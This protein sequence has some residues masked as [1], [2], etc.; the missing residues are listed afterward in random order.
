MTLFK[1][2]ETLSTG[3]ER[4]SLSRRTIRR[5][6]N[7]MNV[8]PQTLSYRDFIPLRRRRGGMHRLL[9]KTNARNSNKVSILFRGY[10]LRSTSFP[11][12]PCQHIYCKKCLMGN[13][14][15][16]ATP[17]CPSCRETYEADLDGAERVPFTATQ[18][19]DALLEIAQDWARID[20]HGGEEEP[21]D[22]EEEETPFINDDHQDIRYTK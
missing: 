21:E 2:L 14:R 4:Y 19:W 18:Q 20:N 1:E 9:R 8:A 12:L 10:P 15:A 6:T 17:K 7:I 13:A 16:Q 3:C 11:S 5:V 22:S